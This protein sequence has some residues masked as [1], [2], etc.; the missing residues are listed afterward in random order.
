MDRD[1]LEKQAEMLKVIANPSRLCI[2]FNLLINKESNVSSMQNCLHE[3][4]STISQHIAKLKTAGLIKGQRNGTEI[5][6]RIINSEIIDLLK[7]LSEAQKVY[8]EKS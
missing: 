6:Y 8:D 4:Q 7:M 3:A 2:L 5:R 1:F